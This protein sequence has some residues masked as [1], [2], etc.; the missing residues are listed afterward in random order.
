MLKIQPAEAHARIENEK[1][2]RLKADLFKKIKK[3]NPI[4][5][6]NVAERNNPVRINANPKI[7]YSCYAEYLPTTNT[8][9]LPPNP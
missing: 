5:I 3:P 6:K 1:F 8:V 2:T 9:C 7:R 4:F